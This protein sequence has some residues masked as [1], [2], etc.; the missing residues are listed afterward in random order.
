M[1]YTIEGFDQQTMY[2][3]KMDCIDA[4][5]LRW[6]IDFKDTGKMAVM[7][8]EEKEY[9]WINYQSL[10]E[11]LPLLRIHNKEVLYRRLKNLHVLEHHTF[12]NKG[13][14]YSGYRVNEKL[15]YSL[16]DK[17]KQTQKSNPSDS[18]VE[19]PID[20]KVEPKDSSTKINPSSKISKE[21]DSSPNF[22]E[23]SK[24]GTV[25]RWCKSFRQAGYCDGDSKF[26]M[27][28]Y[29]EFK[30]QTMKEFKKKYPSCN[31]SNKKEYYAILNNI[32]AKEIS[33]PD[34]KI[35]LA[36]KERDNDMGQFE[37]VMN[38]DDGND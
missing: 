27:G 7:K 9:F 34:G 38:N 1:K 6:F 16:V 24:K 36:V 2:E 28:F 13:G 21:I 14:T 15:Y 25:K 26:C 10:I 33:D 18:K 31:D 3:Y 17:S 5:I 32:I 8:H 22:C 4:C 12:R 11:D 29:N 35:H 30:L 23:F 19:P 37:E 20:S